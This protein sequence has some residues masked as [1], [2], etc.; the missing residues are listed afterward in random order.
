[1]PNG[2]QEFVRANWGRLCAAWDRM[3]PHNPI[4]ENEGNNDGDNA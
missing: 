2:L 4:R 1:M 3:Y